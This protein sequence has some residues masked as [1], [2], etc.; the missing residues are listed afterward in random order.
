MYGHTNHRSP[1]RR[2]SRFRARTRSE[3]RAVEDGSA[4]AAAVGEIRRLVYGM[5]PAALDELGLVAAL[6]QQVGVARSSTGSPMHVKV[7]S[8]VAVGI[9]CYHPLHGCTKVVCRSGRIGR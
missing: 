8:V 9:G 3:E 4:S 7:A 1:R 6:R 2:C 5:R